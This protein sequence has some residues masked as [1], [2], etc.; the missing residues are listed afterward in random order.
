[1]DSETF[2]QVRSD[3]YQVLKRVY[4]RWTQN[5]WVIIFIITLCFYMVN[6]YAKKFPRVILSKWHKRH[7][8]KPERLE[9][10]NTTT[11]TH[12]FLIQLPQVW[13][14]PKIRQNSNR[15]NNIL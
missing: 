5:F 8:S 15:H 12:I 11:T 7:L 4:K 13:R 14:I 2:R 1:L 3:V 6:Y 10:N 9:N